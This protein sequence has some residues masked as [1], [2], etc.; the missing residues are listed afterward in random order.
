M[1]RSR[2]LNVRRA[3]VVTGAII[4]GG[5]AAALAQEAPREVKLEALTLQ[6]P[7][8]WKQQAPE[9]RL[10]LGQFSI[11]AAEGDKEPAELT[12]FN[13][14]S[15]G[16]VRENVRRWI[17]QF[18]AAERM[19]T[20]TAGKCPQGEY[21]FVEITGTYRKPI[22]P[23]VQQR[24]Q[25]APGYRMQGV[26]LAADKQGNYFLKLVGP[27]KTVASAGDAFRA[28]FGARR[29]TEKPYDPAAVE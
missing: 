8:A 20:T 9:N 1:K 13:F 6:V 7:A 23:P 18:E 29:D 3:L 12:V 21:V 5:A 11:A 14:G 26:I 25:P 16:G 2:A 19:V 28:S 10:R 17:D 27:D 4:M 15:G 24:T 22:G